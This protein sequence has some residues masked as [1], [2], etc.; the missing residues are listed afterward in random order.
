MYHSLIASTIADDGVD[1]ETAK[2]MM[3]TYHIGSLDENAKKILGDGEGEAQ[4]DGPVEKRPTFL[5]ARAWTK[6]VLAEKKRISWDTR[7]FVYKLEYDEQTLGLPVGQHLMVRLRDTATGDAIIR[8]YT[9]V[10]EPNMKGYLE[11]LVKVYFDTKEVRGGKM[12][13][14]M[15]ALPIGQTVDF[16][17]PI[18]KFE[19]LGGG[20]CSVNQ[21]V[22]QVKSFCMICG[23][24]GITPIFQ[25]LRAVM[26]DPTDT[27]RCVVFDGNRLVEDILCRDE[28]DAF[29]AADPK[30]CKLI[31]SLTQGP[32][33]WTGLR[34]RLSGELVKEHVENDGETMVL[35]C[36]PEALEKSIHA[37]LLDQGWNDEN[38]LRF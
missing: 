22:R 37:A 23:G 32:E 8:P 24:S 6:A 4:S 25:V 2:A 9:P 36:G 13:Q 5:R 30:K 12:T 35:I 17:G 38:L 1:S 28:L 10:S 19:Y 11:M 7:V 20:R 15:D 3:P 27:T 16:K 21:V 34:G 26:Q 18:G 33:H 29:A 31:Y 14:T